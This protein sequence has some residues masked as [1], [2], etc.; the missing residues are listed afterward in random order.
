LCLSAAVAAA[1]LTAGSAAGAATASLSTLSFTDRSQLGA[2][3]TAISDY[4][5]SKSVK[6]V[7]TFEGFAPWNGTSGTSNP[8]TA[9]GRFEGFGS[10]GTG[11]ARVNDGLS[12][13]VRGD[14]MPWGRYNTDLFGGQ[15]LDSND[16]TGMRW[17]VEGLG[18]FDTLA[19][20]LSDV[21]DVGAVFSM[22]IGGQSFANLAGLGGR[23]ANGNLTLV[24]IELSEAV[25]SLTVEMFNN[26]TNDGFGIDGAAVANSI[27]PVPLPPAAALILA[28]LAGMAG[29]RR[30]RAA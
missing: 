12:A 14:D 6:G 16:M 29:L 9:V 10:Q 8:V 19:F 30:R 3:Q 25:E 15:W 17:T 1:A 7:E 4:L 28:G 13:E 20:L 26:R 11:G 23:L 24:L 2:A 18:K 21:A 5:A 27:A 22:N